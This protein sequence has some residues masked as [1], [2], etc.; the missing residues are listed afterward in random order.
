MDKKYTDADITTID[1]LIKKIDDRIISLL[2]QGKFPPEET[3]YRTK[4]LEDCKDRLCYAKLLL[5][6]PHA[7]AV[8]DDAI[9]SL[10]GVEALYRMKKLGLI[11]YC[12]VIAGR[13]LYAI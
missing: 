5:T 11:E 2:S 1:N 12:G 4:K 8:Y 3:Y 13:K 10:C 6:F 9:I 7:D